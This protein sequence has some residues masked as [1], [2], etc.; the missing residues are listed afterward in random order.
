MIEYIHTGI[1]W[2]ICSQLSQRQSYMLVE[3]VVESDLSWN[4]PHEHWIHHHMVPCVQCNPHPWEEGPIWT[5]ACYT[6]CKNRSKQLSL[7]LTR[8]P[9]LDNFFVNFQIKQRTKHHDIKLKQW[10]WMAL[11]F[12][13]TDMKSLFKFIQFLLHVNKTHQTE[14]DI[15]VI[16][17]FSLL[18]KTFC[19]VS[20]CSFLYLMLFFRCNKNC[21]FQVIREGVRGSSYLCIV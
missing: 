20:F 10:M 19:N 13:V 6:W 21:L 1:C 11:V 5:W 17:W 14:L 7:F 4:M 12:A 3:W 8:Y 15:L 2:K 18:C 16:K 9:H